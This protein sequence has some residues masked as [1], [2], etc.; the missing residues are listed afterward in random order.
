MA[1]LQ[2]AI[3]SRLPWGLNGPR[4]RARL[5]GGPCTPN[6]RLQGIAFYDKSF[7]S[8]PT[9]PHLPQ[10]LKKLGFKWGG[11]GGV[12]GGPDQKLIGGC[13]YWPKQ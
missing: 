4:E 3:P 1:F 12:W 13:V 2:K 9:P 5:G 6:W 11:G 7:T 8:P 10:K